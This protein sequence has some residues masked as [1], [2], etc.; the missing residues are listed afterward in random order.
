MTY[1]RKVATQ[2]INI[3]GAITTGAHIE[4]NVVPD[5]AGRLVCIEIQP[6]KKLQRKKRGRKTILRK[7]F[8]AKLTTTSGMFNGKEDAAAVKV[9]TR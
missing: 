5:E 2:R 4:P 9:K 6:S 3:T 1:F 7:T 8:T